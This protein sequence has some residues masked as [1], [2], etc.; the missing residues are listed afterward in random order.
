M[1]HASP[2]ILQAAFVDPLSLCSLASHI[3]RRPAA[4]RKQISNCYTLPRSGVLKAVR[5][6][7]SKTQ[8][9]CISPAHAG[10]LQPTDGDFRK[11]YKLRIGRYAQHFVDALEMDVNPIEYLLN[12]FPESGLK[13][14]QMRAQLGRFGL[15]G[16]HH[17]QPI[18]KLSGGQKARVVFTSISLSNPHILLFD[19]VGAGSL[20]Y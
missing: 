5:A 13:N 10:D 11:S 15:S 1:T 20:S 7:F 8:Q 6:C 14:E 9:L 2:Q 18:C 12:K 16:H 4:Q 3:C 17:L 19:E